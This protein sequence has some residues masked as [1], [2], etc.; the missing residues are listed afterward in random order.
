MH[1]SHHLKTFPS[2]S[3]VQVCSILDQSNF[4]SFLPI[5]LEPQSEHPQIV[6]SQRLLEHVNMYLIDVNR[7]LSAKCTGMISV[8][9]EVISHTLSSVIGHIITCL[10]SVKQIVLLYQYLTVDT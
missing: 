6:K 1:G 10:L 9:Q 5:N 7:L 3:S 2:V 4:F 8:G